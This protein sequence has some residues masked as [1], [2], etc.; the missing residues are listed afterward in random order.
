VDNLALR[1]I[2]GVCG[3]EN[4]I[5]VEQGPAQRLSALCGDT[6]SRH[7]RHQTPI[8]SG[9]SIR[10]TWTDL[11][12]WSWKVIAVSESSRTCSTCRRVF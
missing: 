8:W 1:Q 3:G 7:L 6:R 2:S 4:D 11:L 10:T 5:A 12:R 9:L